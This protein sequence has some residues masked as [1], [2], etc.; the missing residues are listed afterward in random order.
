MKIAIQLL[1]SLTVCLFP[2]LL[3]LYLFLPFSPSL[4]LFLPTPSF[5]L[6]F[7]PP[8]SPFPSLPVTLFLSPS[9]HLS[10]PPSFSFPHPLYLC[11]SLYASLFSLLLSLSLSFSLSLCVSL[12]PFPYLCLF[13]MIVSITVQSISLFLPPFP[14]LSLILTLYRYRY[15]KSVSDLQMAHLLLFFLPSKALEL[16][17]RIEKA[18]EA[19]QTMNWDATRQ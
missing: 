13:V 12:S 2:V 19:A 14:S 17:A 8:L 7:Y 3:S 5:S 18:A 16:S 1:P 10:L 11:L 6:S 9:F 15:N 4:P